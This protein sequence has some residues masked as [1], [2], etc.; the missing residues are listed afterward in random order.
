MAVKSCYEVL[1]ISSTASP[2]E[3]RHAFR[4]ALARYHPDKV[5]HL[6][7]E[8]HE[9]AAAKTAEITEAYR[10]LSNPSARADYDSRVA[11]VAPRRHGA[12]GDSRTIAPRRWSWCDGPCSDGCVRRFRQEFGSCE[13]T[14]VHGFDVVGTSPKTWR[15]APAARPGPAGSRG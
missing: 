2:G 6:G 7:A 14:P 5:Q 15:R 8:F 3:I 9:I 1:E 13:E 4:R 11:A 10:T 12:T